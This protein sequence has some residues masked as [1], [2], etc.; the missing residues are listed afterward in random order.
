MRIS[1]IYLETELK[2]LID[3]V[4]LQENRIEVLDM[5]VSLVTFEKITSNTLNATAQSSKVVESLKALK[6]GM[7]ENKGVVNINRSVSAVIEVIKDET[8][9]SAIIKNKLTDDLIV[10]NV[11]EYKLFQLWSNVFNLLL[12]ISKGKLNIEI[13][14]NKNSQGIQIVFLVDTK[15]KKGLF[16]ESVYEMIMNQKEN[17]I[18]LSRAVIKDIIEKYKGEI[19]I[20]NEENSSVLTFVL[21]L[22][23]V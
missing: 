20:K 7:V 17:S 12:N 21:P 2:P 5:I 13:S 9:K 16:K 10:N 11:N 8:H 23:Q 1:K 19:K 14:A 3:F 15:I 18:D 4:L 22:N 6:Q